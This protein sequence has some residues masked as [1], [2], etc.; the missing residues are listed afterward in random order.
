VALNS[1]QE[2][3]SVVEGDLQQIGKYCG[4]GKFDLVV[5]NPPYRKTGTGRT[6]V[7]QEQQV[8]RH[9]TMADAAAVVKASAWA[10]KNK[11]RAVLIYPSVRGGTILYEL[12]RQ[13]LEPK[14]MQTVY[15]YPGSPAVLVL[16]EAIKNGGEGLNIMSPF[17]I[18]RERGG[19]YSPEMAS[20]Y[21]P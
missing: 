15:S 9:E 2:R 21:I 13:K 1:W 8:A 17:Y 11:G 5:S 12:K 6:N 3:I 19:E 7:G 10:L 14:R 16:I 20:C 4:A 18:Y